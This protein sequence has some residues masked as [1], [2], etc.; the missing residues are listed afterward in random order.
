MRAAFFETSLILEFDSEGNFVIA[1][2]SSDGIAGPAKHNIL[3]YD[4]DGNFFVVNHSASNILRFPAGGGPATVF[5]DIEDG[6]WN[7]TGI[8]FA[9]DGDLYFTSEGAN[10]NHI[11]RITPGGSASVFDAFD[12]FTRPVTVTA[13]T[14]G[15][16]YVGL[17]PGDILRYQTGN[18]DSQEILSDLP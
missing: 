10:T 7:P 8:A 18:P 2:D 12:L 16:V 14:R 15:A 6:I 3:A 17:G 9:A 11:L 13:D 1:L 5:A 4:A